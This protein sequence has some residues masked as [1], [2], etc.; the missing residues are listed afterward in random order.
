MNVENLRNSTRTLVDD[1]RTW[2]EGVTEKIPRDLFEKKGKM[3][4]SGD[5]AVYIYYRDSGE[6]V[7]V[8]QT[9]RRVKSRLHDETSKHKEAEWWPEW[10]H[11]RFVQMNDLND[12]RLLEALLILAYQPDFNKDP[13]PRQISD[14][15]TVS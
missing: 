10:K 12:R 2:F 5:G 9:K 15:F 14:L 13:G 11:M 7:Y 8:G 1:T 4:D 6:A 3:S